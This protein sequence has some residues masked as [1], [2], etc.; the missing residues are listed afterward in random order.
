MK[1]IIEQMEKLGA[2]AEDLEWLRSHKF[3]PDCLA[4]LEREADKFLTSG[5]FSCTL[6]T[7]EKHKGQ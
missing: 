2:C 7:E 6:S 3:C 5:G 1:I 4:K